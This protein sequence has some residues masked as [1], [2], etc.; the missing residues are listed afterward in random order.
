MDGQVEYHSSELDARGVRPSL[1][2]AC[3]LEYM[4]LLQ[5]N[6]FQLH[7]DPIDGNVI[8][9]EDTMVPLSQYIKETSIEM[10]LA[11]ISGGTIQPIIANTLDDESKRHIRH[12]LQEDGPV[13]LTNQAQTYWCICN[14]YFLELF[15]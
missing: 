12:H 1:R 2:A 10:Q 15:K 9:P 4:R 6:N 7:V 13:V 3:F 5:T 14:I 8:D 11:R